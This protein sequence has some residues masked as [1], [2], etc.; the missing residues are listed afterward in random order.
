MNNLT[1]YII[2]TPNNW[3][4]DLEDGRYI[5]LL[6]AFKDGVFQFDY[7]L[8]LNTLNIFNHKDG[9][10]IFPTINDLM[11]KGYVKYITKVS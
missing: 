6:P 2:N 9:K 10:S 1:K 8:D 7:R 11:A 5:N 4:I 3:C